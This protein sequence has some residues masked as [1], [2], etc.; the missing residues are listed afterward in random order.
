MNLRIEQAINSFQREALADPPRPARARAQHADLVAVLE[1]LGV[2][3]LKVPPAPAAPY[4][5]FTRDTVIGGLGVPILATL[6]EP[7]RRPELAAVRR[8]LED[9]AIPFVESDGGCLEG[10]DV[11]VY[12]SE[13]FVGVGDR[14][15]P[16]AAAWLRERCS[17]DH[18]VHV[19]EMKSGFLHLD[20]V[21]N[22]LGPEHCV[23]FPDAFGTA[24][25]RLVR[26]R[27]SHC[28]EIGLAEQRGRSSNFLTVGEAAAVASTT[29]AASVRDAIVACGWELHLVE[30]DEI[31]KGGGSVRCSTCLID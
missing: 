27:F 24:A 6:A 16:D 20:M 4:Q 8:T 12:G 15:E 2:E 22:I 5:V 18:E 23:Y 21:F 30:L 3:I 17:G 13:V 10:G 9:A 11:V 29:S 25:G 1:R 7:L 26:D 19:L 14:T 28:L 31:Q